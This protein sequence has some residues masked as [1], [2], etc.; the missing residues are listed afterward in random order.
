MREAGTLRSR[1]ALG[2]ERGKMAKKLTY[3]EAKKSFVGTTLVNVSDELYPDCRNIP[4]EDCDGCCAGCRDGVLCRLELK[5]DA[6]HTTRRAFLLECDSIG[7][8]IVV[9]KK[10]AGDF[11]LE[12]AELSPE[13]QEQ[14]EN[15]NLELDEVKYLFCRT[16][17]D[18]SRRY[19]F[20]RRYI[21]PCSR[22]KA[23]SLL[24]IGKADCGGMRLDY[25]DKER[26]SAEAVRRLPSA[27]GDGGTEGCT[28]LDFW[29]FQYSPETDSLQIPP[30]EADQ[31]IDRMIELLEKE[32]A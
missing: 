3:A 27:S 19:S 10:D 16:W 1:R 11:K 24:I 8:T 15:L 29:F 13:L 17:T 14:I 5:V 31:R 21:Y 2:A 30:D 26:V 32:E 23:K 12:F 28:A 6:V 7:T 4:G 9:S 22:E 25:S 20:G 18:R